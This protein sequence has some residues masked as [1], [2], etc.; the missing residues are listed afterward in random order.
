MVAP[1]KAQECGL[2]VMAF[3]QTGVASEKNQE[4]KRAVPGGNGVNS[5]G[6]VSLSGTI[7]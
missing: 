4:Q 3:G 5:S 7:R 6:I 2:G 1:Y